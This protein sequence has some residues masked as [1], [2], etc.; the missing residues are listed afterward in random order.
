M[1]DQRPDRSETERAVD[2]PTPGYSIH[3][4]IQ[5][6]DFQSLIFQ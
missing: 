6:R 1:V 3:S 4:Q 5:I 2:L